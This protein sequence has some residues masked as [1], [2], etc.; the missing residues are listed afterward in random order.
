MMQNLTR[1]RQ[2]RWLEL[3]TLCSIFLKKFIGGDWPVFSSQI[4][5]YLLC[6]PTETVGVS[7]F[8]KHKEIDY[9]IIFFSLI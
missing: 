1:K 7:T 5:P 2:K 3:V 4:Q 8:Q 6:I 9:S